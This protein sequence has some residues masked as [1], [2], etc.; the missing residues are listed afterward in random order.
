MFHYARFGIG[1]SA[2][3]SPEILLGRCKERLVKPTSLKA[4]WLRG[5]DM[6]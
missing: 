4:E 2:I 1:I 3:G 6:F 5:S